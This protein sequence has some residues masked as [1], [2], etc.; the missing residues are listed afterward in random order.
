MSAPTRRP[1]LLPL[2]LVAS[3]QL[4]CPTVTIKSL[5]ILSRARD[6]VTLVAVIEVDNGE[7][8][9]DRF[10]STFVIAAPAGWTVEAVRYQI[11]G[12]PLVRRAHVAT[13]VAAQAD[14]TYVQPG[15]VWWGFQTA[16]HVLP[17]GIATYTA[18]IDVR[19]PRRAREGTL[20]LVVGDPG[21]EAPAAAYRVVIKPR[22]GVTPAEAPGINPAA[23]VE[24]ALGG[25]GDLDWG[26]G[27]ARHPDEWIQAQTTDGRL[28]LSGLSL[29]LPDDLSVMGEPPAGDRVQLMLVPPP[30][31]VYLG[32]L[33]VHLAV[34]EARAHELYDQEVR[35]A[36]DDLTV[37]GTPPTVEEGPADDI[38]GAVIRT[39][40]LVYTEL[41]HTIHTTLLARIGG[42]TMVIGAV[43]G[44]A[45]GEGAAALRA[46]LGSVVVE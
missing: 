17:T 11:P 25:E 38:G 24:P 43:F 12:E 36:V 3:T 30:G 41:G 23:L 14:W 21:A 10:S 6:L 28:Q 45:S 19:V 35:T 8:Y 34:D 2:L 31:T 5:E 42:G 1:W 37:A 46:M 44:D 22:P 27:E 40:S 32:G 15:A 39:T 33:D 16:E 9:S 29:A 18:E 26:F 20:V 4:A 7:A 13:G